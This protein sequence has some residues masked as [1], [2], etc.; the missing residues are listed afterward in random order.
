M[1]R[2]VVDVDPRHL[3]RMCTDHDYESA[4]D[5]I[6]DALQLYTELENSAELVD[7]PTHG[8]DSE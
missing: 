5:A 1:V 2:I 8:G 4:S 7:G 6:N 3:G